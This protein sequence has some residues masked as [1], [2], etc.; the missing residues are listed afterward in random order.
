M[1][2]TKP[3]YMGKFRPMKASDVEDRYLGQTYA[4]AGTRDAWSGGRCES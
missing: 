3:V 1:T 2:Y 4:V